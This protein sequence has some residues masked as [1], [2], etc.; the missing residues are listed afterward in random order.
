[1]AWMD[2][3]MWSLA[4]GFDILEH[5]CKRIARLPIVGLEY[6]TQLVHHRTTVCLSQQ[7][8]EKERSRSVMPLANM[9]DTV[10]SAISLRG[11]RVTKA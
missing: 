8:D 3:R 5:K 11:R 7:V 4:S 2:E 10:H 9:F 1:M 6:V